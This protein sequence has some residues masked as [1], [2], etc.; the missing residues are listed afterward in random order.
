MENGTNG[1]WQLPFVCCKQKTEITNFNI[2]PANG[3]GKQKLV[4]LGGKRLLLFQQKFPS[5]LVVR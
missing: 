5:M 2:F 4:Y 1:K 3:N